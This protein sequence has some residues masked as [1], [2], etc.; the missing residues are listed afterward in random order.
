MSTSRFICY[1]QEILTIAASD[2]RYS[3]ALAKNAILSTIGLALASEKTDFRTARIMRSVE[4]RL[5][6]LLANATDFAGK[7]GDQLGNQQKRRRLEAMFSP[8]C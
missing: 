8:Y 2:Y 3:A 4:T 7:P 6:E 1:L 5:E